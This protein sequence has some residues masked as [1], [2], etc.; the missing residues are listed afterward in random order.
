M[1]CFGY[2]NYINADSPLIIRVFG[3]TAWSNLTSTRFKLAFDN[4]NNPAVQKLFLVPIDITF[5]YIDNTNR[6][7]YLS[8]WPSV[9]LS[10][11]WNM[12][13]PT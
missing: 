10:D 5:R 4:F 13:S 11:S 8:Y 6:R 9:Y 12:G 3:M 1:R 7:K 2:T